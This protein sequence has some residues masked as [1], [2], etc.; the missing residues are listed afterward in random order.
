MNGV[1]LFWHV[2]VVVRYMGNDV[3]VN[4]NNI[5]DFFYYAVLFAKTLDH[6]L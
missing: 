1:F 4:K 5:E 6:T 2:A 3:V